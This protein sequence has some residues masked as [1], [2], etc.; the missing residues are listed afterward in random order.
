L[1]SNATC[2]A[3]PRFVDVL[4]SNDGVSFTDPAKVGKA[5][6]HLYM[7]GLCTS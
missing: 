1:P 2:T 3:T 4:A 6:K 5:A 7:V